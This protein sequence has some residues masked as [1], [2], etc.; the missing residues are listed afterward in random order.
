[1][2][3]ILRIVNHSQQEHQYESEFQ[4]V[5]TRLVLNI[6]VLEALKKSAEAFFDNSVL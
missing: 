5:S 2:Y 1:M 3:A 6:Q 4:L